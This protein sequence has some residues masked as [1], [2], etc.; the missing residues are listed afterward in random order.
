MLHVCSRQQH[1]ENLHLFGVPGLGQFLFPRQEI[2]GSKI[3]LKKKNREE[4]H[5]LNVVQISHSLVSA[6][7]VFLKHVHLDLKIK[8]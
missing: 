5:F 4:K 3:E 2:R 7:S 1:C 8:L 6:S